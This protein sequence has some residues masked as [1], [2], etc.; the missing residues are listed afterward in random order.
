MCL[1]KLPVRPHANL[2][3]LSREVLRPE[4]KPE[5]KRYNEENIQ[6]I[7]MQ[8]TPV[9]IGLCNLHY[10]CSP[11]ARWKKQ[12]NDNASAITDFVGTMRKMAR[13]FEKHKRNFKNVPGTKTRASEKWTCIRRPLP[14]SFSAISSPSYSSLVPL[15]GWEWWKTKTDW[16]ATANTIIHLKK[17]RSLLSAWKKNHL[18]LPA[19]TTS[20]LNGT[21]SFGPIP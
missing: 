5:N 18:R 17:K 3:W 8:K 14:V 11:D 7:K 20:S 4:K 13:I 1:K 2:R 15:V 19:R 21:C 10:P 12:K 16:S 9:C 6:V